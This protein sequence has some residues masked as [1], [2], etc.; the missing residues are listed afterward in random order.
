MKRTDL[1]R[2]PIHGTRLTGGPER[3]TCRRDGGHR[4][5]L[6]EPGL[7]LTDV[8][9]WPAICDGCGVQKSI[10]AIGDWLTSDPRLDFHLC[11]RCEKRLGKQLLRIAVGPVFRRFL[12]LMLPHR[13]QMG[14]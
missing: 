7:D 13:P 10:I 5:R 2:C 4:V 11:P 12:K 3:F 14:G 8:T 6:P 9:D 1:K